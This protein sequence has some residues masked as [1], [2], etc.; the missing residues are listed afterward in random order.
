MINIIFVLGGPGAGKGTLCQGLKD[1]G[2]IHMSLGE[3]LREKA[4]TDQIINDILKG[5]NMVPS[6][7]AVKTIHEYLDS[8]ENGSRV[9]VDGFPRN[10]TNW[11][12]W[13]KRENPNLKI[14]RIIFLETSK[15]IMFK[16]IMH[17]ASKSDQ[18]RSDD[19]VEVLENRYQLYLE[20]L[21]VL[22]REELKKILIKVDSNGKP[23]ETLENVRNIFNNINFD[24]L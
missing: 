22:E 6:E 16:R 20:S 19:R 7:L 24:H 2:W 13:I 5:G 21:K 18:K 14:H 9:L 12:E 4:K 3:C 10:E 15:D 11:E 8:L 1:D 17:R 23:E